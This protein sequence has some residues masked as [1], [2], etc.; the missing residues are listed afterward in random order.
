VFARIEKEFGVPGPIVLAIWGRESDYSTHYGGRDVFQ[1]V[2]TQAYTG[3]RK[4][5]FRDQTLW[6]M[7]MLEGR[8]PRSELALVVGRRHG[9]DPVPAVGV[10]Q[11]RR[12]FRRRRQGRHLALGARCAR[13]RR[14][15]AGRRGLGAR[16]AVG[17]RGAPAVG[18]RLHDGGPGSQ[19]AAV[20]VAQARLCPRLRPQGAGARSRRAASLL[21]PAGTHGPGFLIFHNYFALKEYNFS[22]LYVLFV[23]HLSDRIADPRPF[24]TP[25]K[26]VVQLRTAQLETCRSV[27]PRSA[28]TATSSTARPA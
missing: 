1:M 13:L 18:R 4:D 26:P 16:Q 10:L 14:Q 25:W 2:A 11:V 24:E 5:Y 6:A 7:K 9:A 21:L 20:G 3:R 28:S 22:D 17:L 23:G 27:S 15:A 19:D 12:R 8:H